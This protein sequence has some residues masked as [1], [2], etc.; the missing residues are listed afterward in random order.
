[1]MS[2]SKNQMLIEQAF[3]LSKCPSS[4]KHMLYIVRCL[5]TTLKKSTQAFTYKGGTAISAFCPMESRA[6]P[7]VQGKKKR[8]VPPLCKN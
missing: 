1:M 5:T 3:Q 8:G 6:E 2:I 4:S 7:K